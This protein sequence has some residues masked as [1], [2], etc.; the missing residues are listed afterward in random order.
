MTTSVESPAAA[1]MQRGRFPDFFIAGHPK[2]GTTALYET[3]RAHPQIY[4][5]EIKEL[6]FFASDIYPRSESSTLAGLPRTLE[7]YTSLFGA[8]LPE[9]R[10][11]EASPLYLLSQTAAN[12][13]AEVQPAARVIAILREPA[14]FL[15]S[16]HLQWVRSHFETVKDLR[17]ALSLEQVRRAGMQIP[18]AS[19]FRPQILLYSDFVRYVDQLRR[20][21]A[22]FPQQRVLVL[23]YDDL[24]H[25]NDATMRR[26]LSFLDVDRASPAAMAEVN[27]TVRLRSRHL[28]ELVHAVSVGRNPVTHLAK[29]MLKALTPRQL[30]HR[31]L[32]ATRQRVLYGEPRSPDE[33]LMLELRRRFKGEVV[34]LSEYLDRDLVT[35]WGYDNLD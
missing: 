30:R 21:H 13:I 29:S 34:A 10:T 11:G 2:C 23:I 12:E 27:P 3:L 1:R 15:R 8:A 22:V 31:A 6:R 24:R 16:L 19:L 5:P 25:D 33:A 9:Q 17:K 32:S 14:S 7:T 28:D 18:R 4:M 35:L 26:V 20:Y